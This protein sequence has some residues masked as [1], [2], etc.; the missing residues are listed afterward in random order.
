MNVTVVGVWLMLG[1]VAYGD[2]EW[3]C[4]WSALHSSNGKTDERC[5]GECGI[6]RNGVEKNEGRRGSSVHMRTNL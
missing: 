3:L 2:L 4:V 6:R 1:D 5:L